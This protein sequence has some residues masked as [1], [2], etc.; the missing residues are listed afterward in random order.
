MVSPDQRQAGAWIT[1]MLRAFLNK[2]VV[3]G[4]LLAFDCCQV[5]VKG[6]GMP[7]AIDAVAR[8]DV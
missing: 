7:R 5:N 4:A 6:G 3:D 1:A 8:R 2:T